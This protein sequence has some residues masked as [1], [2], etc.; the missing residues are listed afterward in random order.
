MSHFGPPDVRRRLCRL[1]WHCSQVLI[2][3]CASWLLHGLLVDPYGEF[4]VQKSVDPISSA[5]GTVARS[6]F[7]TALGDP[8]SDNDRWTVLDESV[9]GAW[10]GSVDWRA[11]EEWNSAYTLKLP[12]VPVA[13]VPHRLAQKMLFVGKVVRVLRQVN[14]LPPSTQASRSMAWQHDWRWGENSDLPRQEA[15]D[16]NAVSDEFGDDDLGRGMGVSEEEVLYLTQRWSELREREAFHLLALETAVHE[17][18]AL[19][20]RRLYRL[21]VNVSGLEEHLA[22]L[23]GLFLMG[24][25]SLFHSFFD[26]ARDAMKVKAG[27]RAVL[28]LN[29][30]LAAAAEDAEGHDPDTGSSSS[31]N[32]LDK[33]RLDL[34]PPG[35]ACKAFQ[36]LTRQGFCV[37]G[38]ATHSSKKSSVCLCPGHL[39]PRTPSPS[40]RRTVPG[41]GESQPQSPSKTSDPSASPSDLYGGGAGSLWYTSDREVPRGF[42]SSIAFRCDRAKRTLKSGV[43]SAVDETSRSQASGTTGSLSFVLHQHRPAL[44]GGEESRGSAVVPNSLSVRLEPDGEGGGQVSVRWYPHVTPSLPRSDEPGTAVREAYGEDGETDAGQSRSH[45]VPRLLG[46]AT[47]SSLCDLSLGQVN[48]LMVDY[49]VGQ[50][51]Q[52]ASSGLPSDKEGGSRTSMRGGSGSGA[53]LMVFINDPSRSGS[54]ILSVKLD[55]WKLIEL[56]GGR[57]FVGVSAEGPW[58]T[59]LRQWDFHLGGAPATSTDH[60]RTVIS[61]QARGPGP[62]GGVG[63][64]PKVEEMLEAMDSWNG[65]CLHYRLDWPLHLVLTR[66]TMQTYNRLFRL[67]A[68]VKKASLELERVWPM[69]MQSRYRGLGNEEKAWLGPLWMLRARMAF[70]VSNLAFYLQVDVVEA[71]YAMLR[72]KL[73]IVRDFVSLQRAH[74]DYLSTLRAKFYIDN[75]EISQGLGRALRHVLRFCCLFGVHGDAK[76]IPALEVAALEE[77]FQNEMELLVPVIEKVAKELMMRLDFNGHYSMETMN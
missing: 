46:R 31:R 28:D 72:S 52:Q 4:F 25:G 67:L 49:T 75:L 21:L 13:F 66:E 48:Y 11:E 10:E 12:L 14:S 76:D 57:A 50:P 6:T 9:E 69:L 68:P 44:S 42:H 64:G 77:A 8:G 19:V 51:L 70:F 74:Q 43:H 2:N 26:K 65:L 29:T 23:K 55:M 3:Q 16:G 40:K 59:T 37:T 38:A 53:E 41:T 36:D 33:A 32:T 60:L 27:D 34:D 61:G 47:L 22:S 56:G 39:D 18:H 73:R 15:R 17:A 63:S 20:D 1:V 30:W 45:N 7:G 24:R 71:A 35:F 5:T 62:L 54:P 58:R